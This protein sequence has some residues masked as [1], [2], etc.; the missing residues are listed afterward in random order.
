MREQSG[1]CDPNA[2]GPDA[3][4]SPGLMLVPGDSKAIGFPDAGLYQ[5]TCTIHPSMNLTISVLGTG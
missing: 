5:V 2:Q 4:H 3:L 1:S